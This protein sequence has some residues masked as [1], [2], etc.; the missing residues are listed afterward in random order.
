M[1]YA[2]YTVAMLVALVLFYAPV[3]VL[4]RLGR[5]VPLNAVTWADL[6]QVT[7]RLGVA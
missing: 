3:A 7:E 6:K 2:L 1:M 4:R 5:G